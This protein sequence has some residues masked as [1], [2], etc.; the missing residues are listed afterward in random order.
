[1]YLMLAQINS[2][3]R[4]LNIAF[5]IWAFVN[6]QL[7]ATHWIRRKTNILK[8]KKQILKPI[9][10]FAIWDSRILKFESE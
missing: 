5:T 7:N 6:L 3:I 9:W 4:N 8:K 1:M 2:L 10:H